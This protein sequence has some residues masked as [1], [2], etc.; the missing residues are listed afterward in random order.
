MPHSCFRMGGR[1]LEFQELSGIYLK[2]RECPCYERCEAHNV[3][4]FKENIQVYK[5]ISREK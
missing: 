5:F 2:E 4:S 1:L 3:I